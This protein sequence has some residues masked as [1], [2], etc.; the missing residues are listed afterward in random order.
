MQKRIY[1][2]SLLLKLYAEYTLQHPEFIE[3]VILF[4]NKGHNSAEYEIV[5]DSVMI[6]E[7]WSWNS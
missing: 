7:K 1:L 2:I 5:T 3:N 4:L 6:N